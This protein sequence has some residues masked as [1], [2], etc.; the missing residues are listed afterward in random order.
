MNAGSGI[1]Q[2]P[3]AFPTLSSYPEPIS[4]MRNQRPRRRCGERSR[5][6]RS[7]ARSRTQL[8]KLLLPK[9]W[10]PERSYFAEVQPRKL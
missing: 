6:E 10:T 9:I 1:V 7:R 2:S 8:P 4:Q 3:R 5:E